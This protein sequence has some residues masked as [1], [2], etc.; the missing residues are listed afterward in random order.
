M[1]G[2]DL[3]VRKIRCIDLEE[4]NNRYKLNVVNHQLQ[5]SKIINITEKYSLICIK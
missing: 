5:Q 4:R 3:F 1:L 2:L